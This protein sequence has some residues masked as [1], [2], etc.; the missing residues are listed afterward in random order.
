[1]LEFHWLKR[2]PITVGTY[3]VGN[4]S[5]NGIF[6]TCAIGKVVEFTEKSEFPKLDT[7]FSGLFVGGSVLL[8]KIPAKTPA[9]IGFDVLPRLVGKMFAFPIADYVLDI[10][11]IEKYQQAQREWH[12]LGHGD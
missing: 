1:M 3:R 2:T 7:A 11:T 4:P 10:G 6:V 8:D 9:D 5:Q 12:G